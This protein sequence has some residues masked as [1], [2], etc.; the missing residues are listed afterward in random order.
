MRNPTSIR[1]G[2]SLIEALVVMV[3]LVVLGTTLA[4]LMRESLE[5]ERIQAVSYDRLQQSKTL[6]DEFRA[7]VARAEKAPAEWQDYA[8]SPTT[9]ILKMKGDHH[10]VYVWNEKT[11]TRLAFEGDK[12]DSRVLQVPERTQPEFTR[13][14]PD[15]KVVRFRLVTVH[16]GKAKAGQTLEFAAAVGGDWR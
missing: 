2:W 16:L 10:V 11:L 12:K 8:A 14:A 9:L 3:L 4:L 13:A 1:P 15:S 5:A 7:D 6:A